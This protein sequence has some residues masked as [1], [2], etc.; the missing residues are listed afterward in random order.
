MLQLSSDIVENGA[1]YTDV[2]VI[3]EKSCPV[4]QFSL[5]SH[6]IPLS[7]GYMQNLICIAV[8]RCLGCLFERFCLPKTPGNVL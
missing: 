4:L 3:P 2:V 6:E 7:L 1:E 5:V 8:V